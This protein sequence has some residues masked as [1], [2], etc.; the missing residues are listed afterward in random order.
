[1]VETDLQYAF[2]KKEDGLKAVAENIISR[3]RGRRIR[4][5]VRFTRELTRDILC[6]KRG[7]NFS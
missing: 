5:S 6:V 2:I 4:H 3:I 1:M 7:R